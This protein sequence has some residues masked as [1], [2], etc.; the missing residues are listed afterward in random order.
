MGCPLRSSGLK[1]WCRKR[2][3]RFR[4]PASLT[5]STCS[6]F[7]PGAAL[8]GASPASPA[9]TVSTRRAVTGSPNSLSLHPL[10]ETM[11]DQ[12]I[13][14]TTSRPSRR[15]LH[16]HHSRRRSEEHTSEL[17]SLMRISYA[18]FCFKIKNTHTPHPIQY[19]P[20]SLH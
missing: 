15:G 5:P 3:R 16:C 19:T 20:P 1:A 18:V 4:A 11:H 2:L 9:S 12:T 14:I 6:L 7:C 13:I 8:H 17:Q 10:Q